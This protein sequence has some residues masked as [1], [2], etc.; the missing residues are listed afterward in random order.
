[1][2]LGCPT[3]YKFSMSS[4]EITDEAKR[5]LHHAVDQAVQRTMHAPPED[6]APEI[7]D[8]PEGSFV[9]ITVRLAVRLPRDAAARLRRD[10]AE[11]TVGLLP[12]L[13]HSV[14]VVTFVQ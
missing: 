10:I 8:G 5:A 9:H 4:F 1:M 14:P 2:G 11:A 6:V 7:L 3:C 13:R 12:W